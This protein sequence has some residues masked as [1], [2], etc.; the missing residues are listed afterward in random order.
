PGACYRLWTHLEHKRLEA[1]SAPE[2]LQAELAR[3]TLELA[4]RGVS[5]RNMLVWMEPPAAA[6]HS[7]AHDSLRQLG[8]LEDD[9]KSMDPGRERAAIG[10]HPRL[11][12]MLLK[13]KTVGQTAIACQL[14][15]LLG[16]RDILKSLDGVGN[17][18]I[19][20]RLQALQDLARRDS[21]DL[22]YAHGFE[23]D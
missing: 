14:A 11:A 21:R 16:E 13:A 22:D 17:A 8:D 4:N 19:R 2:I 3:L 18:D 7:Q 15:A 5:D 10:T 20:L 6:A 9:G 12:H 1:H 23:V